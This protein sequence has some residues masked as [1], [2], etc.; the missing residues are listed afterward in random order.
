MAGDGGLIFKRG[1]LRFDLTPRATLTLLRWLLWWGL[2]G[3]WASPRPGRED[4]QC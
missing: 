3:R 2:H 1:I 4:P